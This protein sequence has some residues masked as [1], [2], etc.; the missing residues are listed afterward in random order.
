MTCRTLVFSV[1]ILTVSYVAGDSLDNVFT[2]TSSFVIVHLKLHS[3]E[4]GAIRS[5]K[6]TKDTFINFSILLSK[7]I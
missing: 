2:A 5:E 4:N 1:V 7:S 3:A 6:F